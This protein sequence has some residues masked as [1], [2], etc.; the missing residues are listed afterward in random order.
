MGD[1]LSAGYELQRGRSWVSL[2]ADKINT[3]RL[4]FVVVNASVSGATT[5]DGLQALP[6]LLKDNKPKILIV[7][8]G[9]NDGLRG[10]PIMVMKQNLSKMI[11]MAQ[12]DDVEVLLV[13]FKL[14]SNYGAMYTNAFSQVFTDLSDKYSIQLV[15]FL[16]AGFAENKAYF[17]KDQLHPTAEAQPLIL[18]N[19]WK[20]LQPMLK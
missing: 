3:E 15:P 16:L 11:E 5:A 18:D 19:V 6:S 20:Y 17:Q 12:K 13:G 1:S 2:L 4:D 10:N 8:L 7:A 9:S 14:P